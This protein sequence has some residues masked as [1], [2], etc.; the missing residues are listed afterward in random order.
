MMAEEGSIHL[1]PLYG[2]F[3]GR[4]QGSII[5]TLEYGS[6]GKG[7]DGLDKLIISVATTGSGTMRS[8]TPHVPITEEEI[9]Q[10]VV[11]SWRAGA[12]IAH[13]H[14]RNEQRD[15]DL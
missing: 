5:W 9:A 13:I 3:T 11:D 6:R 2:L 12:A 4:L 15:C 8:Q 7:S 1:D 14:V 10:Q